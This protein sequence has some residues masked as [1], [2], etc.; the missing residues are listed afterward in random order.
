MAE[1]EDRHNQIAVHLLDDGFQHLPLAR[2]IDIVLLTVEDTE[3]VLLPAGN[4]RESVATVGEADVVVI[5]EEEAAQLN[6]ELDELRGEGKTFATWMI[7]RSLALLEG[8]EVVLPTYPMAFCGIARPENFTKM[9]T[10]SSYEPV[11]TMAFAD[12]HPY[13]DEDMTR[14]IDRAGKIG[15]N[16]FVTTEKDAVKI[17]P[18]MRARLKTVGPMIVASLKVSLVAEKEALGQLVALVGELDRRKNR[19][20]R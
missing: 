18:E 11:E 12:H 7:R 8:S 13:S 4:L 19:S 20:L 9:L 1:K 17:T 3:D 10:S 5:R 2:S 16:G 6:E 14:L 15:A